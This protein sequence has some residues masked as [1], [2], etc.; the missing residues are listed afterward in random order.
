MERLASKLRGGVERLVQ[1]GTETLGSGATREEAQSLE[2]PK[3]AS[4]IALDTDAGAPTAEAEDADT[5]PGDREL[6]ITASD[7]QPVLKLDI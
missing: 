7:T 2:E 4:E 5:N 1:R 3:A 6:P